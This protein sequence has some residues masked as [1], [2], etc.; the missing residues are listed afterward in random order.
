MV[1]FLDIY[2]QMK[3]LLHFLLLILTLLDLFLV[4]EAAEPRQGSH[5]GLQKPAAPFYRFLNTKMRLDSINKFS[6]RNI[7]SIANQ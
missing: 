1:L 6:N 4:G 5:G 7:S 2:I 3:H